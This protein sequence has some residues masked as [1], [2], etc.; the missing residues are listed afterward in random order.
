MWRE[1]HGRSRTN[2][3][4]RDPSAFP[5]CFQTGPFIAVR[6]ASLGINDV[7]GKTIGFDPSIRDT[8]KRDIHRAGFR[9]GRVIDR[10]GS[11]ELLPHNAILNLA[12]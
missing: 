6:L 3:P 7:T 8:R 9:A 4:A 5:V 10:P 11:A 2:R 12:P 1:L